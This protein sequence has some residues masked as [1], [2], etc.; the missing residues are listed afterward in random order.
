L[1]DCIDDLGNNAVCTANAE[2]L[3][4]ICSAGFCAE[5]VRDSQCAANKHCNLFGDCINDL[6]PGNP[7]TANAEC[8]SGTC[9]G[10]C[11]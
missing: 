11:L 5:C 2:C 7:C 10:V 8:I 6:G 4:N 1:G 9:I 3:S